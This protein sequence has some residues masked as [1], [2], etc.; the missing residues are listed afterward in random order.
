MRPKI[1]V[2]VPIHDMPNG[3]FFLWRLVQ[4]LMMQS[5]KDYELVITKNGKMAENTNAAIHK[6]RGEIVKILYLDDYLAHKDSLKVIVDS[7][8]D[9]RWLTTGCVHDDGKRND[10]NPH[11]PTYS[12]DIHTGHNTIGSPSVLAFRREGCLYFDETL[13]WL[14]DC[15]LYSRYND[16]YG[17]PTLCDDLNVVVGIHEG[18]TSNLMSEKEKV[19]EHVYMIKKHQ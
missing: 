10:L 5:F 1:S 9:S 7:F 2:C 15:D 3:D 17:P 12:Q 14:L 4:S 8:G 16:A 18:Q 19:E 6:A 13:S 11:L